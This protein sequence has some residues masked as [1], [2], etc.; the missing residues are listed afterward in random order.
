M[1]NDATIVK[2]NNNKL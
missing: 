2:N 1:K